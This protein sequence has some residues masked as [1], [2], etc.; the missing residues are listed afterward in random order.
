MI[1]ATWVGGGYINGTSES[2]YRDGLVWAQAPWGYAMSLALGNIIFISF[3][4]LHVCAF[5]VY[6]SVVFLRIVRLDYI[7]LRSVLKYIFINLSKITLQ[8]VLFLQKRCVKRNMSQCWT[9]CKRN[10]AT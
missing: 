9:L 1:L 4:L 6:F 2:V 10:M 3:F 7:F 8:E 5:A